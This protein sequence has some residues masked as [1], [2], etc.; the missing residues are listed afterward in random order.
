M[1]PFRFASVFF[2]LFL[3]Y[4]KVSA[5]ELPVNN[6]QQLENLADEGQGETEDESWM[7]D[8]EQYKKNPVNLNLA[9]EEELR[10]LRWLNELQVTSLIS[11][12]K[13]LGAL[14]SLYEL[15]A[16]PG[17][18]IATIRKL[19]P[20]ITIAMPLKITG[21][22]SGRLKTGE[23]RV[24]LRLSQ[25]LEK[26][27]G[28]DTVEKGSRYRGSPQRMMLRYRYEYRDLLQYGLLG[29]KDAG[30][31]F[32]KGAQRFGFDFYSFHFFVRK[33][34]IVESLA[35]GDF[36]INLGQ[37][38]IHWQGLAFKK[39]SEIT[40]VKRQSPVLRPYRSAGEFNF[41]RG[42]GITL[43]KG[44]WSSTLFGS[45]RQLSANTQTDSAAG[46]EVVTSIL[47][48]GLHRSDNEL[49]DRLSLRQISMGGNIRF[50]KK[51]WHAGINGVYYL[52]SLPL[53]K[54]EEP[55]NF[56][57]RGGKRWVNMSADYSYSI[58][59]LHLFGETAADK[60]GRIAF[61]HGM[62][63]TVDGTVD[64]SLLHRYIPAA[65]QAVNGNAFTEGSSP[66]NEHGLFAGMVIRPVV[67][68]KIDA[69][70]DLYRFPWLKYQVDAPGR[71]ADYLLQLTC[72]LSKQVE[73]NSRL[74]VEN[75]LA[76]MP[77]N[78][79]AS[80]IPVMIRKQGWRTQVSSRLSRSTTIRTRVE[81]I[82]YDKKGLNPET[83]FL[84]FADWLYKP[85]LRPYGA[86]VRL[87]FF[88]TDGYNARIYAYEN[89]VAFSYSIPGFYD[90]GF[91][92][93]LNLS[94]DLGKKI[95]VWIRWAQTVYPGKMSVG[96][97]QDAIFG[98]KKSELRLQFQY[99]F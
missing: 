34:G 16:V 5:Q 38:L 26:S 12:R 11:Y 41:H 88:E 3:L 73:I 22:I 14:I 68:W 37:G 77:G 69:Y 36:T 86:A 23:H 53:Q 97:G 13:L 47:T 46:G 6:E 93:Y 58:R 72:N 20:F 91:R 8:I 82:W 33:L 1:N 66:S 95:G 74:R 28:Y 44:N 30:E 40:A 99:I 45:M 54:R 94:Y 35:I 62:L 89:D 70:M 85:L 15:Q 76:N 43:K 50:K 27:K 71:G 9:E 4:I 49:A 59:N 98:N 84:F 31:S 81:M 10:Q 32:F 18:D 51:Q 52:F 60:E 19:I 90:K 78:Q 83:G 42:V 92:Y 67:G 17:W 2:F 56:Y 21:E 29:D 48:G 79:T 64:L 80:N 55:Y 57:A 61:L 63:L 25:V 39:S 24:L 65:Y 96:T 7:Q 87:Q 75:K